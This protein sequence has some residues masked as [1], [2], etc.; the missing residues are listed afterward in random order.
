MKVLRT[1]L[2]V[3][4]TTGAAQAAP[5]SINFDVDQADYTV[6]AQGAAQVVDDQFASLGLLIRDASGL[7]AV[8]GD[9]SN[10]VGSD[11]A[12]LYGNFG[13]GIVDTTPDIN[14]FF[15]DT[16]DKSVTA[17]TDFFSI[18]VTDGGDGLGTTLSAFDA[19]DN[20]VGSVSTTSSAFDQTLTLTGLGF[21]SRVN[22]VTPGDATGYDDIVF[23]SVSSIA[24]TPI[25]LPASGL[26]L[27]GVLGA[28]ACVGRRKRTA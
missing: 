13:G 21:F 10:G 19:D 24:P 6:L 7:G 3:L 8:V 2:A 11:P 17:A 25:P 1:F 27:L 14:F 28:T 4:A 26:L 12:H 23:E 9:V 5:I 16:A 22:I 20:L 18:L 15:V